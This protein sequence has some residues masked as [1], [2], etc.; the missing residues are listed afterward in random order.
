MTIGIGGNDVGFSGVAIRC[1]NLLSVPLGPP[2][3]GRPCVEGLT[4]NGVDRLTERIEKART[5]VAEAFAAVRTAA[6]NASIYVIG[7]PT[8]LPDDGI[9]CWP[10]VPLLAPD[11]TYLRDKFVEMNA[12]IRDEADAAGHHFIDIYTPSIGHDACEPPRSAWVNG[13]TLDPPGLA[14]HPNIHSHAATAEIVAGVI[15]ADTG[16][17]ETADRS[18]P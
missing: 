12:M 10:S 16:R 13:L 11:V 5:N 1:M 3:F 2:P 6:P 17:P 7:Y 18:G 9:G 14:L 8:A 4:E 15:R